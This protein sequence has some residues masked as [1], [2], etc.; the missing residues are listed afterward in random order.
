MQ[1]ENYSQTTLVF[2]IS[3]FDGKLS[4]QSYFT[5]FIVEDN[6]NSDS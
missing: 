4:K 1:S 2:L 6:C 3:T 5:L